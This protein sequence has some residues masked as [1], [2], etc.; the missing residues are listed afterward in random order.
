LSQPHARMAWIQSLARSDM[1][2]PLSAMAASNGILHVAP[3]ADFLNGPILN[4]SQNGSP[5]VEPSTPLFSI[6][7]PSHTESTTR[8][9]P[10]S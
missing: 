7:C 1:G 9:R 8:S 10:A 4:R 5:A 6:W 2:F 3:S